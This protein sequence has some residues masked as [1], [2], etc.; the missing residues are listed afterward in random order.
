MVSVFGT[1]RVDLTSYAKRTDLSAIA[2]VQAAELQQK[3]PAIEQKVDTVQKSEG[4]R[5]KQDPK[6]E[7]GDKGVQGEKGDKSEE[8]DKS[9][10]GDK[11]DTGNKG[12]IG[13]REENTVGGLLKR[14][15]SFE[16]D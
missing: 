13:P 1:G 2:R 15:N 14:K 6:G 10:K 11:G 8:G 12:E 5:G 16:D 7:G 3:L 9:E 4:P